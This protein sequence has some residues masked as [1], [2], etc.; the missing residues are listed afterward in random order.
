MRLKVV[1]PLAMV[2]CVVAVLGFISVLAYQDAAET[3]EWA[4][5]KQLAGISTM[6]EVFLREQARQTT[7]AAELLATLPQTGELMAKG[8]HDGAVKL[9]M[10]GYRKAATKYGA[11]GGNLVTPPAVTVL[12]LHNPAK[13]GDDQSDHRPIL[14][15]A[16]RT[17]EVQS[18]LEIS[19]VV[20]MRGVA[21]VYNGTTHVGALEWAT[22]LGPTLSELKTV[23]GAELTMLIK[24][25]VI[26]ADSAM[27]KNEA[28][29]LKDYIAA[30]ATD[31]TYLAGTLRESD[32][33]R[34]S[35]GGFETRTVAGVEVGVVKVPLFDF[36]GKNVG[37]ILA[38]KEISEFG[39][40]LKD[41]MVRLAVAAGLGLLVTAGVTLLI[42]S[43]MMLRPLER[44]GKRLKE[45][46][47]GD[48]SS[49][50]EAIGRK[51]EIGVL[52]AS[53]ESV[54]IDLLRRYPPGAAPSLDAGGKSGGTPK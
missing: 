7:A 26:P 48:F 9:L 40:T 43:G 36:T 41:A 42:I 24:E 33:E 31:W 38:V 27:R 34:V 39:R 37:A 47:K 14:V 21:P 6:I 15:F 19:A 30:E 23:T 50:V 4:K 17:R 3:V 46:A 28:R 32:V 13:F 35:E 44:L 8:D 2:T 53:I 1:A 51:D 12:R 49:K 22:G 29:K 54:R 52:A 45:L 18:G 11:E 25:S 10:P 16:N 20:G 5:K